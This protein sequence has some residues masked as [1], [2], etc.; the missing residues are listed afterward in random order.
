MSKVP[1]LK[2]KKFFQLKKKNFGG[3][4]IYGR[5]TCFHRGRR[6]LRRYLNINTRR[7][8]FNEVGNI[9][10]IF[11]DGVRTG[12]V[13][14]V[15]YKNI[16]IFDFV[17]LPQNI[18]IGSIIFALKSRTKM[19]NF[20]NRNIRYMNN[21]GNSFPL[22][23]FK[24]GSFVYNIEK[25]P[26]YGSV[27]VRAAGCSARIVQKIMLKRSTI[28]VAI[29]LKSGQ[30]LY[31]LGRCMASLGQVSNSMYYK[32]SKKKAGTSRRKGIRPVVRG[33]AMNPVDH[34]HGGGEGKTSGG[35]PSV[36]PWGKLTKGQK[37]LS[38]EKKR[39][40]K[41]IFKKMKMGRSIK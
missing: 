12:F 41:N 38:N 24:V 4:N 8:I 37:T 9:F 20:K 23:E 34:P 13:G 28:Y 5:Q 21:I 31:L 16:G 2:L 25:M 36:T 32:I 6:N 17:L 35:R 33:V 11:K 1:Y 3:R 14:L 26:G 7:R 10:K 15:Y 29:R 30:L 22:Q 40:K 39:R 27:Y 19:S 18:E